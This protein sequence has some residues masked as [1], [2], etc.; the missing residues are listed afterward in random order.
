MGTLSNDF[1]TKLMV[2]GKDMYTWL[3]LELVFLICRFC[4]LFKSILSFKIIPVFLVTCRG[5]DTQWKR[6]PF[7]GRGY[8]FSFLI[9]RRT[10]VSRK[11]FCCSYWG[12]SLKKEK[13]ANDAWLLKFVLDVVSFNVNQFEVEVGG[14]HYC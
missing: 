3:K 13:K 9:F 5:S 8:N 4:F 7:P 10:E 1:K 6:D 11:I 14:L 2:Y 12:R